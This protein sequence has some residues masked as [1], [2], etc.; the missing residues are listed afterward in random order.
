MRACRRRNVRNWHAIFAGWLERS[1]EGNNER[2][3]LLAHHYLEAARP[4]DADLAWTGKDEQLAELRRQAVTWAQR[5]ATLALARY[6]VD[7]AIALLHKA[8]ELEPDPVSQ[9]RLWQEIGHAQALKFDGEA[10]WAAMQKAIDL[11]GPA[12]DLYAELAL[13]TSIRGAMW[14]RQPD[15]E[16]V[17]GW[18]QQAL[19]L[20]DEGSPARAK[21][22]VAF[23]MWNE[24]EAAARE[25]YEIAERDG[26]VGLRLITGTPSPLQPG[27]T[28][29][30]NG[31]SPARGVACLCTAPGGHRPG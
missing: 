28:P 14:K 23:S 18:I 31:R 24:D 10:F 12:A 26:D 25:A 20:A 17:V 29:T 3:G 21:A 16:L 2:A 13:Q 4:D 22:L 30:L 6:E 11:G 15:R 1:A 9:A 19:D 5:A 8:L 27:A 7:E